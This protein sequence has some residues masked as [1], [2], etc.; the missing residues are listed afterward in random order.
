LKTLPTNV[1]NNY[2]LTGSRPR[3]FINIANAG[4]SWATTKDLSG[5][6]NRIYKGVSISEKVD[7]IGGMS[8]VSDAN[9]SVLKLGESIKFYDEVIIYPRPQGVNVG[10]GYI[11]SSSGLSYLNARNSTVGANT[12]YSSFIVGQNLSGSTFYV[13]RGYL[14]FNIPYTLTSCEDAYIDFTFQ[15]ESLQDFSFKLLQGNWTTGSIGLPTFNDFYMW[16]AS[17]EYVETPTYKVLNEPQNSSDEPS[18]TTRLRFNKAGRDIIVSKAGLVLKLMLISENDRVAQ[19]PTTGEYITFSVIKDSTP[20]LKLIYNTVL[21]DNQR[22]RIYLG[23]EDKLTALPNNI[24]A[25]LNVWSGVVDE[26]GFTEKELALKLRHDDFK[27]NRKLTT[28]ILTTDEF[29]NLPDENTGKIKPIVFGDFTIATRGF[30][31]YICK[32][33]NTFHDVYIEAVDFFKSYKIS[34]INTDVIFGTYLASEYDLKTGV[35]GPPMLWE[36]SIKAIVTTAF[37]SAYGGGVGRSYL[38]WG[39]H[40][41]FPYTLGSENYPALGMSPIIFKKINYISNTTITQPTYSQDDDADNW[42]IFNGANDE[43]YGENYDSWG[44]SG[45][46]DTMALIIDVRARFGFHYNY[47]KVAYIVKNDAG[48]TIVSS[49]MAINTNGQSLV[50]IQNVTGLNVNVE[51]TI[52]GDAGV[53]VWDDSRPIDFRNI[54]VARGFSGTLGNIVYF[55]GAGVYD[56][57]DGTFTGEAGKLL[58]NPVSL[59][60]WFAMKKGTLDSSQIDDSFTEALSD[61]S[62]WKFAFQW[63]SDLNIDNVFPFGGSKSIIGELAKQCKSTVIWNNLGKLEMNVFN[64]E[65]GFAHSLNNVPRDLDIF[66]LS[67]S[68]DATSITKH[69]IYSYNMELVSLDEVYNDFVLKYGQNYATNEYNNVLYMTNGDGDSSL[70]ETN[71]TES[72]LENSQ[73]LSTLKYFTSHSYNIIHTT[74][75]L[76]FEAWAIRD[77]A[78]A[79]KLLQ[80]LIEWYTKRRWIVSLTTGLNALCF[81][82]GDFINVRIADVQYQFGIASMNVK[83]WKIT[84]IEQNLAEG[85]MKL[86]VIESETY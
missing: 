42:S 28:N 5:F 20:S 17:G 26:W 40:N 25:L 61:L 44:L 14:Q 62:V 12:A 81:E 58:E 77:E 27:Y 15:N 64:I 86:E 73:T 80:Y 54:C 31:D 41:Y 33:T 30:K 34:D 60:K 65:N 82:I 68:P 51:I 76:E 7:N 56:E 45:M 21:P 79:N 52:T 19:A 32:F 49:D 29:P 66:E 16:K 48:G 72:Y 69:P 11:Y 63:S 35:L 39:H 59:I 3:L 9:L 38:T 13:Y 83:K 78:T 23:F 70:V 37:S 4:K 43:W 53:G 2:L 84:G 71:M 6:T 55:S 85:K 22:A 18:F 67:G 10:A 24:S 75:T 50:Y 74:N 47:L 57:D 46:F 36:D 1:S 8:I